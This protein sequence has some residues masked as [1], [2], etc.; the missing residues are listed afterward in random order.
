VFRLYGASV[1]ALAAVLVYVRGLSAPFVL[2]D[3]SAIVDNANLRQLSTAFSPPPDTALSGRPIVHATFAVNYLAGGLEPSGYR[4]VNLAV[5]LLNALLAWGLLI[6]LLRRHPLPEWLRERSHHVALAIVALWTLHPLQTELV[7]YVVQRTELL[8]A[9]SILLALWFS[10]RSLERGGGRRDALVAALAVA[11]GSGCKE[12]VISAPALVLCLDLAFFSTSFRVAF[13]KHR[14]LYAGLCI[15]I[16]PL[17]AL[18]LAGA[19][20]QTAG[21]GLGVS[22]LDSLAV[23]GE[24]IALYLSLIGW[25]DTLS[26]TYNWPVDGALARYWLADLGVCTLVACTLYLSWR[27]SPAALPGWFF[28]SLLAPSSSFVPIISEVVAERRMY[29]PLAAAL[30][31]P[32][33][34][35]A[36]AIHARGASTVPMTLAAVSCGAL[37]LACAVRSFARVSDYRTTEALFTSALQA[38]PDNP[39]AMWG[40]GQAFEANGE[41]ARALELYERMAATPYPYLGPASW[42]T[43]GLMAQADL[44]GRQGKADAAAA[45]LRRALTHDPDSAIGGLQ[46]AADLARAGDATG[47]RTVLLGLL[48]QPFLH[49][50]I[51]LEIGLMQ[52]RLGH[53]ASAREHFAQALEVTTDRAKLEARIAGLSA[54]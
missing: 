50:R 37:A 6:Q 23:Q 10:L 4:A 16:L 47:A 3:L 20:D 41:T 40:L 15:G 21:F 45:T 28:F 25:P 12:T 24:A 53:D 42:G 30:S 27:K 38:A 46:H 29:L 18:Q 9:T 43:R 44:L 26:I 39:Q 52:L 34:F 1:V 22:P 36:R 31:I 48:G 7:M 32:V 33:L 35:V 17:F 11:I 5:H 14:W 51:H 19:R 49:D 2:D 54:R 13:S 8:A